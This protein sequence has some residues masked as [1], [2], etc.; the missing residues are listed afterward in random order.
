MPTGSAR[1]PWGVPRR[2][3]GRGGLP[4]HEIERVAFCRILDVASSAGR[5]LEHRLT[6][7]TTERSETRR[8]GGGE[9]D[10]TSRGV[11]PS[12]I[13]HGA[14]ETA[15]VADRR[16]RSRSRVRRDRV[17]RR[18]I[19]IEAPLLRRR[20]IQVVNAQFAGLREE[21]IVDIRDVSHH[22]DPMTAVDE[23]AYED[24]VSEKGTGVPEVGRVV[25][26]D[27]AD[28]HTDLLVEGR[29]DQAT[30]SGVVNAQRRAG[31]FGVRHRRG[32]R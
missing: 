12:G 24:V 5:Q 4:E 7:E 17:E 16:R 25:G 9:V 28:I 15:D 10:G 21:W 22:S 26:G 31:T 3:I 30:C 13:E 20:E 6:I 1:P 19:G 29:L 18:H 23:G 14:D 11:R 2:L 32:Y 27:A 8:L